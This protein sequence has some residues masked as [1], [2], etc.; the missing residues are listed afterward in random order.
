MTLAPHALLEMH[1]DLFLRALNL[2]KNWRSPEDMRLGQ[3]K[4]G[5]LSEVSVLQETFEPISN[6]KASFAPGNEE[7]LLAV[8]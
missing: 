2:T 4:L 3:F 1:G 6:C 7:L 8:A 5:G